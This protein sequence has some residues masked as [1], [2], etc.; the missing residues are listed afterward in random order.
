MQPLILWGGTDIDPTIYGAHPLQWTDTPDT[1]RDDEEL[2]QIDMAVLN[3]TPIIGVCRGAQLLC[4]YNGGTLVQHSKIVRPTKGRALL[5]TTENLEIEAPVDHHQIMVPMGNY[6][7]LAEEKV[8][9]TQWESNSKHSFAN[10]IPHVVYYPDTNSL[11]VQPHP[12]WD[13]DGSPFIAWLNNV[14]INYLGVKYNV[15]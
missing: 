14:V 8:S 12:E 4:A 6:R 15:F 5:L 10:Y 7:I 9:H 1:K 2:Y 11:A 3:K 13:T